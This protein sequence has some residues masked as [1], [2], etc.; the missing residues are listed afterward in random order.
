MS[1]EAIER[2]PIFVS[3]GD[4]IVI[5]AKTQQEG[6][7]VSDPCDASPYLSQAYRV[8]ADRVGPTLALIPLG[9]RAVRVS[10]NEIDHFVARKTEEAERVN[11]AMTQAMIALLS[12]NFPRPVIVSAEPFDPVAKQH[13]DPTGTIP[14]SRK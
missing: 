6:P 12:W 2:D 5:V 11:V 10:Q 4:T 8:V 1:T 7:T 14:G 13:F 9:T 3:D